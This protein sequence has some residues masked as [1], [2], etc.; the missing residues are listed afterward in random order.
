MSEFDAIWGVAPH[1][2]AT[3]LRLVLSTSFIGFIGGCWTLLPMFILNKPDIDFKCNSTFP[4]RYD[5]LFGIEWGQCEMQFTN[6][7][8]NCDLGSGKA[9]TTIT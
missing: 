8:Y 5:G 2:S 9:S 6:Q 3:Q 4:S 7:I 1:I